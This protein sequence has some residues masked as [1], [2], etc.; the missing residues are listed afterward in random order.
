MDREILASL[1]LK[2]VLN[3]PLMVIQLQPTDGEVLKQIGRGI[4]SNIWLGIE[5]GQWTQFRMH[6]CKCPGNA[7]KNDP[8]I[9]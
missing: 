7:K 6:S 5:F 1:D 9:D 2:I 4:G 3:V 8:S